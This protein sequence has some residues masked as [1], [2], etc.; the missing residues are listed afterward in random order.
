[1]FVGRNSFL[2]CGMNLLWMGKILYK[3]MFVLIKLI[4]SIILNLF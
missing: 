2:I 4:L 1:M 3:D